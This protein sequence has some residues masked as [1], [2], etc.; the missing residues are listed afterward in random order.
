MI[1]VVHEELVNYGNILDSD[2]ERLEEEIKNLRS[3]NENLK[4][5]WKG[6]DAVAF[7]KNLD[8]Y[9]KKMENIIASMDNISNFTRMANKTFKEIDE[10][11]ANKLRSER[12]RYK[13][14]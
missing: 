8:H 13:V 9:T 1:K 6:V 5:I 7:C 10:N 11:Y 2:K 3:I 12:A 14:S 4:L